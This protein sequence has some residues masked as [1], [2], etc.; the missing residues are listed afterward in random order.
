MGVKMAVEC[1]GQEREM[2]GTAVVERDQEPEQE[3]HGCE[4]LAG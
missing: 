1:E 3:G 2:F 4:Q